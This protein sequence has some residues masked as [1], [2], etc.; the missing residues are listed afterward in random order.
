MF[1][2][3]QLKSKCS[4]LA[5]TPLTAQ[6]LT[7]SKISPSGPVGNFSCSEVL[8]LFRI[9]SSRE[10]QYC[11][12]DPTPPRKGFQWLYE[13]LKNHTTKP[14]GRD[15]ATANGTCCR[16]I[17][18]RTRRPSSERMSV[19]QAERRRGRFFRITCLY[20]IYRQ[21]RVTLVCFRTSQREKVGGEL[22]PC[23]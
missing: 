22:R 17:C 2:A 7:A 5:T 16:D 10:A 15:H 12:A 4:Q 23:T 11:G 20:V 14:K 9:A 6:A 19:V 1:C 18:D 3:L 8:I 21:M 13:F